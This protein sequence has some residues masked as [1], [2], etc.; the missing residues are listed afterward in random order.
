MWQ[1][2]IPEQE[3]APSTAPAQPAPPAVAAP[4]P[5]PATGQPQNLFQVCSQLLGLRFFFHIFS[6]QLAQQRQQQQG[7]GGLGAGAGAGA[8]LGGP[9]LSALRDNNQ[10]TQLRELVTQNPAYI[11]PLIQQLTAANPQLGQLFAD[12]PEALLNFLAEEGEGEGEGGPGLQVVNVTPEEQA[13]IER[14]SWAPW[15]KNG[16]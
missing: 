1:Q 16:C 3:P 6:F 11:Q 4:A 5:A 7:S 2:G 8:G 9:G 15:R 14:V 13:A 10:L 12:N